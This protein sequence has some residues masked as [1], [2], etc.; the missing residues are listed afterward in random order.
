MSTT[1]QNTDISVRSTYADSQARLAHIQSCLPST[2]LALLDGCGITAASKEATSF[3]FIGLDCLLGRPLI[4]TKIEKSKEPAVMGKVTP[5]RNCLQII[6]Q[7][8]AFHQ[9]AEGL[10]GATPFLP[11]VRDLRVL[12]NKTREKEMNDQTKRC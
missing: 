1:T 5:G 8:A 9:G 2:K 6:H 10:Q 4:T 3:S 12:G 7:V 11:P